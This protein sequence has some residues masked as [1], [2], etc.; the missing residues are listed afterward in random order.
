[1]K[2]LTLILLAVLTQWASMMAQGKCT[3]YDTDHIR[4]LQLIAMDDPFHAP[5][6]D[7]QNWH[8]NLGFDEMSHEYHRYVYHIEHCEADWSV[9]DGIFESNFLEGLNDQP[10]EDYEKSF[11]TVQ[12][13][14][15]YS[16]DFPNEQTQLLISGN[17][18]ITIYDDDDDEH[19]PLATAEF[20]LVENRMNV[21]GK[22]DSNTDIDFQQKH[23]QVELSI[24]YGSLRVTDPERELHTF[25]IQNRRPDQCVEVKPNVR[26]ANGVEF[27]HQRPLIFS[28]TSEYHKFELLDVNHVNLNVDNIRWFEPYYHVTLDTYRPQHNYTYDEDFNGG[29]FIRNEENED[30]GTTCEYAII[31]FTLKTEKLSGGDVYIYGNWCNNWP[32]DE[33]KMQYDEAEEAYQAAILLKQGYY[34][35]QFVQLTG[36]T[37]TTGSPIATTERTE[38]NFYQTENE[39]QVLV[40]Y[41]APGARYDRLVGYRVLE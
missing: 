37:T 40:Y 7:I 23:Q 35:Y 28:G 26:K 5:V 2:R 13:Y 25:V 38:G 8:V 3:I 33:Y 15:H 4:S 29:Y 21:S 12:I 22:V 31:H 10:I 17:Y 32:N 16:I 24:D 11:N 27:K 14:T 19:A 39:Y 1:M 18:R 36:Q 6:M 9:S 30:N 41:R 20:C 34:N